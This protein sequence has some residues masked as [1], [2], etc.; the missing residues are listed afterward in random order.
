MSAATPMW[1]N[2]PA[3]ATS[4]SANSGPPSEKIGTRDID[5][6][7]PATATSSMPASILAAAVA[8]ASTPE[9]HRRETVP[10]E[11]R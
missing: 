9:Q 2:P 5:S 10:P 3:L 1:T 11:D 8:I 7:P 6:T 4:G